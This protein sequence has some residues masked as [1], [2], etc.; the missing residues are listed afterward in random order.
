MAADKKP[1]QGRILRQNFAHPRVVSTRVPADMGHKHIDAG[2]CEAQVE[3][4][5]G[6]YQSVI[7]VAVHPAQGFEGPQPV[8]DLHAAEIAGMPYLVAFR[9]ILEYFF[10]EEGMG[11]GEQADAHG[12]R[13]I[14]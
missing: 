1:V 7:D 14:G 5:F 11:V 3:R 2:A 4:H 13:T 6:L 8:D 9:K 12:Y 10:V